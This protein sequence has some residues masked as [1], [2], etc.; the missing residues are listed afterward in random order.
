M[1][2]ELYVH[3]R[4]QC[5]WP[6]FTASHWDEAH[7][8]SGIYENGGVIG[9][10]AEAIGEA[11]AVNDTHVFVGAKNGIKQFTFDGS[12]PADA[13]TSS[14]FSRKKRKRPTTAQSS[15]RALAVTVE[16]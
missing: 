2:A 7:R 8:E 16:S 14:R 1:G 9:N 10:C 12:P 4:G 11:V 5:G 13:A 6:G 3:L 15:G